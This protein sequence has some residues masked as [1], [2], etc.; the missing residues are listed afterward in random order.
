MGA[1]THTRSQLDADLPI[2]PQGKACFPIR[3]YKITYAARHVYH[4]LIATDYG[5]LY[6]QFCMQCCERT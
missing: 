4:I 1:C 5:Q 2:N 3:E 6:M